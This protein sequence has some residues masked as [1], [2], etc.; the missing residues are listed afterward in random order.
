[1]H[2]TQRLEHIKALPASIVYMLCRY[3]ILTRYKPLYNQISYYDLIEI[4]CSNFCLLS[5]GRYNLA[6][7]P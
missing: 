7:I 3:V 5:V 6:S 1:M 2:H 4:G